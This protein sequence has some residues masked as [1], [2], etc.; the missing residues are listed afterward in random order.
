MTKTFP[1]FNEDIDLPIQ[2]ALKTPNKT[3][4]ESFTLAVIVKWLKT[5]D[6]QKILKAAREKKIL[7]VEIKD[8]NYS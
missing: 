5:K 1:N 7:Y 2:E 4:K 8:K 3:D 6:K